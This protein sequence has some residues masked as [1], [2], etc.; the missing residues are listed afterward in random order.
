MGFC[1]DASIESLLQYAKVLVGGSLFKAERAGSNPALRTLLGY[2]QAAKS[3][4]FDSAIRRFESS[5]PSHLPRQPFL[6]LTFSTD[7]KPI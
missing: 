7:S 2:R 5:Y 6:F 1:V 4:D 3:A